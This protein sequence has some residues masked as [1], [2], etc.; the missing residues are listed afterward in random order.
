MICLNKYLNVPVQGQ[1]SKDIMVTT[2]KNHDVFFFS[3]LPFQ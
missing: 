3:Q 1:K 2:V